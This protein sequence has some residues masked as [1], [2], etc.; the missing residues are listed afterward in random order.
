L[1]NYVNNT[2]LTSSLSSYVT[3]TN[4]NNTISNI[5]STFASYVQISNFSNLLNS[6][7]LDNYVTNTTLTSSLS[8]Y[9]TTGSTLF[10]TK[11]YFAG[12][13]N[14]NATIKS[15]YGQ[16]SFTVSNPSTGNYTVTFGQSHPNGANYGIILSGYLTSVV[17]QNVTSTSF[18]LQPFNPVTGAGQ[19][20]EFTFNTI[21]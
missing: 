6:Y 18:Q 2:T 15:S 21:P 13:I 1:D 9:V 8:S 14:S 20:S 19:N 16:Y 5:N 4:F 17:Y 3:N 10:Q 12:R 7:D 11:P